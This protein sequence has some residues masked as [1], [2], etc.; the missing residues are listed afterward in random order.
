MHDADVRIE[1]HGRA[2]LI[3]IESRS[4]HDVGLTED[5]A[6][7]TTAFRER[8]DVQFKGR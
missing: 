8:R 7:G 3:T 4:F 6:E 1:S 2:R 5:L